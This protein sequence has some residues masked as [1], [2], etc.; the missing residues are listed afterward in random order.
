MARK[1]KTPQYRSYVAEY[2]ATEDTAAWEG[3]LLG[4]KKRSRS[5]KWQRESDAAQSLATAL[6][7][8]RQAGRPCDGRV[9]SV[10]D[11]AELVVHCGEHPQSVGGRCFGCGK[12]ITAEDCRELSRVPHGE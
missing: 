4:G 9:I 2:W 1:P 5:C 7:I 3:F 12:I 8:N 10:D 11:V 6:D